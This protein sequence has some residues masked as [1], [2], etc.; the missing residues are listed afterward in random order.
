MIDIDE[1]FEILI[2]VCDELPDEMFNDLHHGVVLEEGVKYSPHARNKDL[3][4]MGEY[5]R[6]GLGN[7]ISIYYGSFAHLYSGDNREQLKNRLRDVVR[8]EFRHHMEHLGGMYGRDSLEYEDKVNL[9][10]YLRGE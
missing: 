8:H 1:F 5:T 2:E 6:S 3:V 4:I 10:K 9:R 7:K